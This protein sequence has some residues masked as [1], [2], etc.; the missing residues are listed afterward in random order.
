M[1]K[2]TI[3]FSLLIAITI[4]LFITACSN[5]EW[6]K[7]YNNTDVVLSNQSLSEIIN[8]ET[9]LT[10]FHRLMEISGYDKLLSSSQTF[11]VW[12]PLDTDSAWRANFQAFTLQSAVITTAENCKSSWKSH[13]TLLVYYIRA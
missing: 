12:A 10:I 5:D 6:D 8:N 3:K 9:D 2:R 13:F 4:G 7:H 1:K 11:T